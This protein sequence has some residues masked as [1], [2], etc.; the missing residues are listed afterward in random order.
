VTSTRRTARCGPACRVVWQGTGSDPPRPYADCLG[1]RRGRASHP[2]RLRAA[3]SP[4]DLP[5]AY[6]SPARAA[7]PIDRARDCAQSLWIPVHRQGRFST[8]CGGCEQRGQRMPT[9]CTRRPRRRARRP[10]SPSGPRRRARRNPHNPQLCCFFREEL[11]LC[12][13]S[14]SRQLP[15]VSSCYR[16]YLMFNDLYR[17]IGTV[18]ACAPPTGGVTSGSREP[19][20]IE[21]LVQSGFPSLSAQSSGEAGRVQFRLACVPLGAD[22]APPRP[23]GPRGDSRI[24][25]GP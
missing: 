3:G 13:A 23:A 4:T 8:S 6:P 24:Q 16:N 25:A 19:R 20:W 12:N 11:S 21:P 1:S 22:G 9:A 5:P 17:S 15:D 7:L 10:R 18:F 14:A 2:G